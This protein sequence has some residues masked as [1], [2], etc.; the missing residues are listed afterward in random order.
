MQQQLASGKP[1]E[2]VEDDLKLTIIKP[3]HA[4][5]LV[6]MYNYLSGPTGKR[7]I[8]KGWKNVGVSGLLDS[9]TVIPVEN[10]FQE[11]YYCF[12]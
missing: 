11:I 9:T 12:T 8:L 4:Q 6:N 5:W 1:I 10:P 2:D 7:V 3:L